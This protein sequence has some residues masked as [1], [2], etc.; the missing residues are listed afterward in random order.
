MRTCTEMVEGLCYKLRMFGVPLS[1]PA[2]IFCDNEAAT[3]R[4]SYAETTLKKKHCSIAYHRIRE[5]VAAG[6]MLV[7]YENT[8]SNIADLLTK[9]LPFNK[10]CYLIEAILS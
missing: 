7:Y 8:K 5:A 1:G 2:R 10:R 9:V 3:K 6:K 4:S